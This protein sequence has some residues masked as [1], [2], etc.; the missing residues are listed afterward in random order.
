MVFHYPKD[1]IL[2]FVFVFFILSLLLQWKV[3]LDEGPV[4]L[5]VVVPETA[6]GTWN[7]LD[8]QVLNG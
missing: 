3:P 5:T 8:K 2:Y 6:P 7:V 4:V 1:D